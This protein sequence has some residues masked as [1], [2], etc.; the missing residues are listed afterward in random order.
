MR[1]TEHEHCVREQKPSAGSLPNAVEKE[2]C[3]GE[4]Q[5]R[6]STSLR[7]AMQSNQMLAKVG[8]AVQSLTRQ[9]KDAGGIVFDPKNNYD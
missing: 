7:L 5:E 8:H 2:A 9:G 3:S 1:P 4:E 6:L